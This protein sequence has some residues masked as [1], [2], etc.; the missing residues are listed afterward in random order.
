MTFGDKLRSLRE[1][2][3][4]SQLKLAK[5][6]GLGASTIGQYEKNRREPNFQRLKKIKNYFKIN[7]WNYL[8]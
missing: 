5:E 6:L 8:L 1:N 2:A 4:L 3:G 7:S